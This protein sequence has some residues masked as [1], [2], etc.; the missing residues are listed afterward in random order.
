MNT[1]LGL[2]GIGPAKA[3]TLYKK[4]GTVKKAMKELPIEAQLSITMNLRKIVPRSSISR[5]VARLAKVTKDFTVAGSYRREK[6]T[7]RDIDLLTT[8]S[9]N[10]MG[11]KLG[12]AF[13]NVVRYQ[14]G[15]TKSAYMI[16][17]GDGAVKV[18]VYHAKRSSWWTMLVYLTGSKEFNIRMRAVAKS[19]GL[20]LNQEGLF[21][22]KKR[23]NISSEK[24]LFDKLGMK[25]VAP[26]NRN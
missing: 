26:K 13:R 25:W 18:D 19:K 9:S 6:P 4:Y 7:S 8:L 12:Q 10:Q 22:G 23:I 14:S 24:D 20:L 2:P 11:C 15:E 16:S 3:Q 5:F 1:F 17:Y 21:L